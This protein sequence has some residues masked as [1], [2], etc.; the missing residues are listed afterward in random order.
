[1]T[2]LLDPNIYDKYIHGP[3]YGPQVAQLN[4][5]RSAHDGRGTHDPTLLVTGRFVADSFI[6][7]NRNQGN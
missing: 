6:A 5:E 4:F 1:M 7:Y 3:E 2:K